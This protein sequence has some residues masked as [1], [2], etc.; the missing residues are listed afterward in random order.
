MPQTTSQRLD[1]LLV[2]DCMHHGIVDCD[3]GASLAEVAAIMCD[4]RVHAVAV[5]AD[6]GST[7]G[8]ISAADL[9]AAAARDDE[10]CT[11]S[12]I[13]ATETLSVTAAGTLRA[14][15]QLMTEHGVTHLLVRDNASGHPVGVLSTSDVVCA[16]AAD[17]ALRD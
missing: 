5:V 10:E 4:H 8:I 15:M 3:P 14:A 2:I 9:I 12:R 13:A 17:P 16:V 11:A 1:R 6:D 7:A